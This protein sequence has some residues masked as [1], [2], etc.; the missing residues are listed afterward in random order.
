MAFSLY[1]NPS[2]PLYGTYS[3]SFSVFPYLYR[4]AAL[5]CFFNTAALL[6]SYQRYVYFLF[7]HGGIRSRQ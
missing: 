3:P 2:L 6:V 5:F 1:K 4:L 7:H